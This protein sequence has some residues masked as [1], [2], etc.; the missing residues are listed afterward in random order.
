V[1]VREIEDGFAGE[2]ALGI[3][4]PAEVA[5]IGM[6]VAGVERVVTFDA[7]IC[8]DRRYLFGHLPR[9]RAGGGGTG[10]ARASW[11]PV[12]DVDFDLLDGE[13]REIGALDACVLRCGG[14]GVGQHIGHRGG[15][16]D[17]GCG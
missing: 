8:N 1:E 16:G 3:F 6:E 13:V 2:G 9:R 7:A 11:R 10:R 17:C 12:D 4:E 5:P 14:C 15:Q